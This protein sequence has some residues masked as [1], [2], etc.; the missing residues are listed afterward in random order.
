MK[1]KLFFSIFIL[2]FSA[3]QLKSQSWSQLTSGVTNHLLGVS[4]PTS[5]TCYVSGYSG[6]ILK[7]SNGG[8]AWVQQNSGTSQHLYSIC[9]TDV[10]NGYAVGD[11]S[12]AVKTT[13]GGLTWTAMTT[14]TSVSFR[15]IYFFNDTIGYITGGVSGNPGTIL[16]TTNAGATWV[17]I[18]TSGVSTN[19]I[20]SLYFTS[21]TEGYAYDYSGK[22]LKTVNGGSNWSPVSSGTP[23][24]PGMLYFNNANDGLLVTSTGAISKTTNA[25]TSWTGVT[26]GTTDALGGIDFFDANN[27]FTVGGNVSGN[28]A[29]ILSTTDAG[30]TWSPVA[31]GSG[32]SR[33]NKVDFVDQNSGY[34]VGNDGAILK[35]SSCPAGSGWNELTSGITNHL[36]GVSAPNGNICYVSGYSGKILKTSNGGSTWVQQNSGTSQHLYSICFTDVNNGYAVGDNSSAVKTTNG[37]LTWTAMTT[38]TS[39]SFRYIYF[40]NDTIGYITGGVSGNP[41]T[42]LKTID[43]GATWFNIP[44]SGV[45]TNVIY[46]LYFTSITNGYAYDYSGKVLKTV[47]GGSTWSP[48]SS[49]TPNT[50]GMLYFNNPNDGLLVTST[51]AI[52]KT[53]NAGT[54]WIGVTSGTTDALGG[55]DFFDAN[56]GFTVGGNISGNSATI[57]STT[58]AGI[59]WSPVALG[60]GISRLN[61]V[62]FVDQTTGYVVGNDGVILKYTSCPSNFSIAVSSINTS[63]FGS[64]DGA[65]TAVITSSNTSGY[66]CLWST[67]QTTPSISQLCAGTYTITVT[68]SLGFS[69][70]E[71]VIIAE[72]ADS[73]IIDSTFI[74]T[75]VSSNVSVS[76]Y[77]DGTAA[78]TATG[79]IPPYSYLWST[80]ELTAAISGLC[81]NVYYVTVNDFSGHSVSSTVYI[82]EPTDTITDPIIYPPIDTLYIDPIDT[83]I[84]DFNIPIDSAYITSFT[85]INSMTVEVDWTLWQNGVGVTITTEIQYA[86]MGFNLLVLTLNCTGFTR[87]LYTTVIEDGINTNTA[88]TGI[89]QIEN[90]AL[91]KAYPNPFKDS[92]TMDF[93]LTKKSEVTIKLMNSL[94]QIVY[95]LNQ[96]FEKGENKMTI[97]TENLN[98][99]VYFIQ[100]TFNG[101]IKVYK[102]IK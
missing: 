15:Y 55:I 86:N 98:S 91:C 22:V 101:Q 70:S 77:C 82:S 20:Y 54:S 79:G 100:T 34:V 78:V 49:G 31:L 90:G 18:P 43:A 26:S 51:G 39:V 6:K 7:T 30:L 64:C 5:N 73:A 36:L 28:T 84:V 50:P 67:G 69:V 38:G 52:R 4:A 2:L 16:K 96:Q 65:A 8:A 17:N 57:L 58:D 97:N 40:F 102:I 93:I 75:T 76:G 12:S 99:G 74:L 25:G 66:S 9:F 61:K 27:G 59:T 72:P 10:N 32:I 33:L 94:G 71:T 44:T 85:V 48:V 11:N 53:T 80:G 42:I 60:S 41:G 1:R 88:T 63:S 24:T 35:Y 46:S 89:S 95:S 47:N 13:N 92:I 23:N 19:V 3:Y 45:S 68:D 29:T 87:E 83:C 81:S 56:N 14:G 21:I 37:G 62:D